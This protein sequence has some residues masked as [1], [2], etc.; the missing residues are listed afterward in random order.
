VPRVTLTKPI[1]LKCRVLWS[2]FFAVSFVW[3]SYWIYYDVAIWN[4][5]VSQVNPA[6]YAGSIMSII[7]VLAGVLIGR[8]G[9]TGRKLKKETPRAPQTLQTSQMPQPVSTS[10]AEP[11]LQAEITLPI[12]STAGAQIAPKASSISSACTHSLGYLHSRQKSEEIP[13]EC[14]LCPQVVKCISSVA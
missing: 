14:L 1:A 2:A 7:F 3:F 13:A 11:T 8:I 9:G 12:T 6:N 5:P 4:K 10:I